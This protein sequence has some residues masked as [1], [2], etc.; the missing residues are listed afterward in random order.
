LNLKNTDIRI[1]LHPILAYAY[2]RALNVI[3]KAINNNKTA[4]I[5]VV[6]FVVA[7]FVPLIKSNR[8]QRKQFPN[9]K[10]K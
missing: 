2:A 7:S 4:D 5:K 6:L 9:Q 8:F 1:P 10:F 3:I